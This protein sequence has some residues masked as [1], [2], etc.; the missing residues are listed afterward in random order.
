VPYAPVRLEDLYAAVHES[1][2]DDHR[3]GVDNIWTHA[4][5]DDLLPGLHRIAE[6]LPQAPSHMLW[7][8]WCPS[9]PQTP[10]RPD[11]AYSVEDQTYVAVYAVWQDPGQDAANLA[12]AT[13]RMSELEHLATGIQLADENLGRRPAPFLTDEHYERYDAVRAAYDPDGRF[14]AWMGRP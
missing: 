14:H 1:Y 9:H 5:I 8:N 13:D 12:W 11:M 7:M 10:A 2:P 3:Y 4:P 6:T